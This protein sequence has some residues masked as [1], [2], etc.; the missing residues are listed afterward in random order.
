MF[1]MV[2][3]ISLLFIRHWNLTF[4]NFDFNIRH[5]VYDYYVSFKSGKYA[6]IPG[7]PCYCNLVTALYGWP[8][9]WSNENV[10]QFVN[11]KFSHCRRKLFHPIWNAI[12]NLSTK[13]SLMVD[14]NYSIQFGMQLPIS[15]YLLKL[16][17]L[18]TSFNM[19]ENRL[20]LP[21]NLEPFKYPLLTWQKEMLPTVVISIIENLAS[22]M[23]HMCNSTFVTLFIAL[24]V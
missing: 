7:T 22:K 1:C 14:E 20:S 18:C 13:N 8:K 5:V 15:H 17:F 10:E 6:Q 16:T 24:N 3:Q 21:T 12:G 11:Q 4:P 2:L 23:W 19:G 9:L